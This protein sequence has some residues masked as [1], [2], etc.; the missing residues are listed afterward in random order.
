MAKKTSYRSTDDQDHV[1]DLPESPSGPD[2]TGRDIAA[3]VPEAIAA[4]QAPVVQEVAPVAQP[5]VR[6]IP[7]KRIRIRKKATKKLSV[8]V[9]CTLPY[10]RR[11]I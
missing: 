9:L 3:E 4:P 8:A 2:R 6:A 10:T 5:A 11:F 1:L 7:K